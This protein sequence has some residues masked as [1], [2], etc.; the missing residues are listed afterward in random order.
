MLV[1]KRRARMKS[2]RGKKMR[3][4]IP[5]L[6]WA[7]VVWESVVRGMCRLGEQKAVHEPVVQR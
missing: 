4:R 1:Q 5:G 3:V 6:G 7:A 2:L